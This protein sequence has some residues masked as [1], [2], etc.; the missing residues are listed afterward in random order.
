[1]VFSCARC[2]RVLRTSGMHR[3]IRTKMGNFRAVGFCPPCAD[4]HDLQQKR[5]DFWRM[6]LGIVVVVTV[7][8]AASYLLVRYL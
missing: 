6:F 7:F 1:M 2:N 8:A 3:I 5:Q 4:Q